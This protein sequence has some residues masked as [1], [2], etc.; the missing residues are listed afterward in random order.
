MAMVGIR[1]TNRRTFTTAVKINTR[2]CCADGCDQ[3]ARATSPAGIVCAV[4]YR[5]WKA[6]GSFGLPAKQPIL[7]C[8]AP[9]CFY[10]ARARTVIFCRTHEKR[11][12]RGSKAGLGPII[13]T[14]LQCGGA[15]KLN[16]SKFCSLNCGCR[17][18]RG[19][20][21]SK[22]CV[23]CGIAFKHPGKNDVTCSVTCIVEH[24]RQ[25]HKRWSQTEK[26]KEIA[27]QREYRR[28][29]RKKAVHFED[30]LR[31]EIFE[32]DGWSCQICGQ[33]VLRNVKFPHPF[34]PTLDHRIPL[35]RG[36]P[37][38]RDNAQTAHLLCNI[39]KSDK[40]DGARH[41]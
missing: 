36:G 28:K 3:N 13:K 22:I 34:F 30:F 38:T 10:K 41:A 33:P 5:R 15:L 16:Q 37:H 6:R 29:A 9:G 1:M 12:E 26:F 14:C 24:E 23:N 40:I 8:A 20:P 27:R 32:R 18:S 39:Q 35:A 31:N 19:T 21:E 11:L 25:L 7:Q 2:R 4:H 17:F